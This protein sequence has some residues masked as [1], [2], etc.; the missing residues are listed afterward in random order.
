LPTEH[1]VRWSQLRVGLVVIF[2]SITLGVLI[3]L[4]TGATGLF[5]RKITLYANF[6]N[7]EGLRGGAPVRLAGVDIGNVISLRIV[8]SKLE[9]PVEVK[10]SV[11]TKYIEAL[12][13]NSVATL[14]TAGVLGETFVDIVTPPPAPALGNSEVIHDGATLVTKEQ[15]ALQDVVRAS[16]TTLENVE[17]LVKRLDRIVAQ[18]ESGSGS[19]GKFIYDE[20]LYSRVNR[21]LVEVQ[22]IVSGLNNGQGTIGKLLSNDE[23][24][25]KVNAAANKVNLVLDE[26]QAGHGTIG[27]L[28][29]DPSLYDNAN[30][31]LAKSNQLIA[32]INAGKGAIGKLTQDQALARKL[33]T[34]ITQLSEITQKINSG[35]GTAARLLTDPSLYNNTD[36]ML[37]ETR[38]L[39]SAIRQ[40]PKKY[41]TIHFRIF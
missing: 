4:M 25:V 18:V 39:I 1:Q 26:V 6:D 24:Y 8:S 40:N 9:T 34:T 22:A 36:Q 19:V 3:F 16:Q 12:R 2:A 35:Q 7:A 20:Q 33:D 17:I 14:A 23:L 29:K 27:K 10:M 21:L 5:T 37:I 13:T 15:P 11:N 30:S 38:N 28:V 41:L 32:D 31:T